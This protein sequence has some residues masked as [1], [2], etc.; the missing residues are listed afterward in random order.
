MVSYK[1][2]F[3]L[4]IYLIIEKILFS[5]PYFIKYQ[6]RHCWEQNVFIYEK[7]G[8][9]AVIDAYYVQPQEN[10]FLGSFTFSTIIVL[11]RRHRR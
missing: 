1:F 3:F 11:R 6:I 5:V 7:E 8:S 4:E 2:K 10:V 9:D